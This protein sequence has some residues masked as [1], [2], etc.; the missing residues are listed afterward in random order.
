MIACREYARTHIHLEET[1]RRFN[2][3]KRQICCRRADPL[4][5]ALRATHDCGLCRQGRRPRGPMGRAECSRSRH[6]ALHGKSVCQALWGR[7]NDETRPAQTNHFGLLCLIFFLACPPRLFIPHEA[8]EMEV[9]AAGG[10]WAG[11]GKRLP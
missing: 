1:S 11:G 2:T 7:I 8:H 6:C 3:C 9:C 5:S 4:H 10:G